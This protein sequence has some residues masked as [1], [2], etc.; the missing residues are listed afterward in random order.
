MIVNLKH[1][2]LILHVSDEGLKHKSSG[3]K[4]ILCTVA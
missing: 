3:V 1:D 2:S 4:A